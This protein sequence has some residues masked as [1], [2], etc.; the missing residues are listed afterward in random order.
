MTR[1]GHMIKGLSFECDHGCQIKRGM[2]PQKYKDCNNC[3]FVMCCDCRELK[4]EK[5]KK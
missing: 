5:V 4:W 3:E 1:K 2:T